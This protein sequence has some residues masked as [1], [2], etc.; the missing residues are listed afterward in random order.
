MPQIV[1]PTLKWG[2]RK[3][4][5][6]MFEIFT[7]DGRIEVPELPVLRACASHESSGQAFILNAGNQYLA[8]D[9][10]W[11]QICGERSCLPAETIETSETTDED[12]TKLVD[13]VYDASQEQA[14]LEEYLRAD[15]STLVEKLVWIVA[16]VVTGFVIIAAMRWLIK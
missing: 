9:G 6:Q 10:T 15:K 8:E 13:Q 11:H 7:E 12:L 14:K 3:Q 1:I 5:S 16:I 2:K 4:R